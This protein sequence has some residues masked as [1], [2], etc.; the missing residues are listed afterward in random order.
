MK[1]SLNY[2]FLGFLTKVYIPTFGC[3]HMVIAMVL[4]LYADS[5]GLDGFVIGTSDDGQA[6]LLASAQ[7]EGIEGANSR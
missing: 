2:Y 3:A 1:A 6:N 4:A 5:V 7:D